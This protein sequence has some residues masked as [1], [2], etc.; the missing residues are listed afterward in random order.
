MQIDLKNLF[1]GGDRAVPFSHSLD[2]TGVEQ[3][4]VRPF[5]NPVALTGRVENTAGMVSIRYT[6]ATVLESPCDRCLVPVKLPVEYTFFHPLILRMEQDDPDSEFIVVENAVLDLDEL[7]T[8]DI[9]LELPS[10]ILCQPDCKGL[11]PICGK[12]LNMESCDC[13]T[14]EPDP[15]LA[16]LRA[17]L[18]Q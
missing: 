9:I 10:K 7:A 16:A 17:L 13:Q 3:G 8:A 6:A 5:A 18:E 4:G 2:L 12:N 14:A 11:C 15:R 1:D